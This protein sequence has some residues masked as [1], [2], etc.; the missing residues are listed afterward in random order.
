MAW[1]GVRPSPTLS[2]SINTIEELGQLDA[3]ALREYVEGNK[4]DYT[5]YGLPIVELDDANYAIAFDEVEADEACKG[6][7]SDSVWAFNPEF[8]ANCTGLPFEIF[9]CIANSGMCE[10]SNGAILAC[11][12][13]TCGIDSFV[14]DAIYED[15]R[16]HFLNIW[17][18]DEIVLTNSNAYAYQV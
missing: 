16:G 1:W 3:T 2:M 10:S 5:H 15:G 6:Y 14:A 4:E 12:E 18:G 17:D 8:I 9:K 13:H 11:I 7:I